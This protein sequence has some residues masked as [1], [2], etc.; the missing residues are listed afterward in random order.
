MHSP[1]SVCDRGWPGNAVICT[2]SQ[3]DFLFVAEESEE[4]VLEG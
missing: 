4:F 1:V 3:E 2:N